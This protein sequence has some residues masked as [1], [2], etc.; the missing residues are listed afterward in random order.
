MGQNQQDCSVP[1]KSYQNVGSPMFEKQAAILLLII[2]LTASFGAP[3]VSASAGVGIA[4]G[5]LHFESNT[6][7]SMQSLYVINTGTQRSNY[8]VFAEGEYASWFQ[9]EP[10]NFALE[11]DQHKEVKISVSHP[12]NAIGEHATRIYVTAFAR[13]DGDQVGTGVK[14]PT[15][16]SIGSNGLQNGAGIQV[17]AHISFQSEGTEEK[18]VISPENSSGI[19]MWIYVPSVIAALLA[20]ALAILIYRRN[21][22]VAR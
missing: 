14:V 1:G 7:G 6:Q 21:H 4:P 17:P 12:A 8:E 9:I 5:K 13:S 3:T 20:A 19:R 16:I 10:V 18:G 11:P 2:L 22:V 15:R